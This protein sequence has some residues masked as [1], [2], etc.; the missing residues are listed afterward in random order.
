MSVPLKAIVR[1]DGTDF[2]GWQVQPGQRTVQG[3]IEEA[4]EQMAGE[5]V[6]V[7]GAGRTDAGV[8]ALAQV[9]AFRWPGVAPPDRLRR[10]LSRMLGP[11]IRVEAI[12]AVG[13]T[14]HPIASAKSKRY[15]YVF[16]PAAEPDPLGARYAWTVS[17]EIDRQR[18][19][20]LAQRVVGEHDFAGFC[21]SGSS[22]E[23]T[24]RTIYS[25]GLEE[26]PLSG[27]GEGSAWRLEFHGN[28]FLYK[29]VRNIVG[30]LIDVTRGQVDEVRLD[31]LLHAPAPYHGFTAPPQGLFLMHVD[32][33]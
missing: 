27:P 23:T 12:E 33:D 13:E 9:C 29:M 8:H 6:R 11:E 20:E 15:G 24:V 14:F 31:E 30:T 10:S 1:Y 5:P 4:L 2:V 25:V 18:V 7:L 16:D 3:A 17:S 26:G 28:G 22:V 32:Y 19:H 21:A